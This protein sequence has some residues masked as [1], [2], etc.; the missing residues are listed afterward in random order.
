[1]IY[2]T[3]MKRLYVFLQAIL[4]CSFAFSQHPYS[5]GGNPLY[6][7][8]IGGISAVVI[9]VFYL[10]LG[11]LMN[12]FK[13]LKW[14]DFNVS[15]KL[16]SIFSKLDNE[17]IVSESEIHGNFQVDRE[18]LHEISNEENCQE[19][20]F[21]KQCG[22]QIAATALYCSYCGANQN[23]EPSTLR[24]LSQKFRDLSS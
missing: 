5:R 23:M 11:W 22:K 12:L 9:Y 14:R 6:W 3:D 19:T 1:M 13:R 16:N 18:E 20:T 2:Q 4:F 24:K 21:C 10:L 15:E 17:N 7:A 8:L